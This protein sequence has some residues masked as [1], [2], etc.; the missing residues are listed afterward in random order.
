[1]PRDRSKIIAK[2]GGTLYLRELKAG[3]S[4]WDAGYLSE[5]SLASDVELA[6]VIDGA[7]NLLD[8]KETGKTIT[9]S[10]TLLQSSKEEIDKILN[11]SEKYFDVFYSVKVKDDLFQ[12]IYIPLA[13]VRPK[14]TVTYKAEARTLAI[15][16]VA[17]MGKHTNDETVTTQNGSITVKVGTYF[18]LIEGSSSVGLPTTPAETIKN[19]FM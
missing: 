17:L 16:I 14:G 6:K 5:V 8:E 11:A 19:K 7:G 15:E 2:G 3:E 10:A 4:F 18:T 13:K 9:L 1:M 12:E